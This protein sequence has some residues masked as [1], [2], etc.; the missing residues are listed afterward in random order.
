VFTRTLADCIEFL[1]GDHTSLRELLHPE[2]AP[3]EIGY[4]LAHGTLRAG[5][6][7]KRH[8]LAATEVYYIVAGQGLFHAGEQTSTVQAGTVV[9][10]PR[11]AV[12]WVENTGDERLEFLCLVEPAWTGKGEDVLE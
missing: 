4:S 2:R 9:Y 10:V 5:A 6:R 1:A 3:V 7:S 12:Q 8:R 11:G